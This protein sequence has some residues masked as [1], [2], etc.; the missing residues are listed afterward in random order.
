MS[1]PEDRVKDTTTTTGTG[2]ITL[3]GTAPSGYVT[4][5]S[6]Y[7][8]NDP[9]TYSIDDGAGNWE[10]GWGHL[11]ASTTLVRD[12]VWRSSNS[13]ALVSFAAGSKTVTVTIIGGDIQSAG[14]DMAFNMC[15]GAP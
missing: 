13:N 5:G 9:F 11:S 6:V 3:S 8:T 12:I 2:N 7:A 14:Q 4:F 1:G 15:M 10:D